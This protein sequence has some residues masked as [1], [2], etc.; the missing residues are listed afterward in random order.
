[1]TRLSFDV[2]SIYFYW[3]AGHGRKTFIFYR[4]SLGKFMDKGCTCIVIYNNQKRASRIC[5][6]C[7]WSRKYLK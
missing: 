4:L 2:S 6:Y 7:M 5:V 3:T 1:M